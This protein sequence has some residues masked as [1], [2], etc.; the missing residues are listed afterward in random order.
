MVF[1]SLTLQSLK[2]N[3]QYRKL[4]VTGKHIANL[5]K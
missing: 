1:I 3:S 2:N 5:M 4:A